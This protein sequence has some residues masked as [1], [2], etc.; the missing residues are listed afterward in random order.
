[1][2]I[3]VSIVMPTHNRY[4]LNRLTLYSLEAQ[5]YDH[6]RFEVILVDDASTDATPSI[7]QQEA[8][9]FDV[10]YFRMPANIGRPQARNFGIQVARGEYVMFLDAEVLVEPDFIASHMNLHRAQ[11]RLIVGGL[12]AIQ[13][14]YTRIDPRFSPDQQQEALELLVR[15]PDLH[16]RWLM[17]KHLPDPPPL[18]D[19][20]G[21]MEGQYKRMSA[22]LASYTRHMKEQVIDRYGDRFYGFHLPWI[23]SGTGSLSLAHEA[24]QVHGL[25]EEY[26]GWGA[27]DI[28][29]GYRLFINGY[30]F[31]HLSHSPTYHQEHPREAS[32][33]EEGKHNFYLFQ[34]KHPNISMLAI[35]LG[36]MPR[37][38]SF[39][40]I[41]LVLNDAYAVGAHEH[42]HR[43]LHLTGTFRAMLAAVGRL[44]RYGLPVT[45]LIAQ[46]GF[47]V[48]SP[49]SHLFYAE[50]Q[51]L[52]QTGKYPSL[53]YALDVLLS[54]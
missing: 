1:M 19:R 24:F 41:N 33:T 13:K 10:R 11:S 31:A 47:A 21:I 43:F 7:T 49:E 44:N 34:Q 37:G 17:T 29:M 5:T 18:F 50:K 3:D 12:Y 26:P 23:S 14:A 4:P 48:P 51:A 54:L 27:D 6:A 9:S 40:E 2:P 42:P 52:A 28:E 22:G 45:N 30:Q 36:Y 25:F 20:T 39:G 46:C 8:F 15:H 38:L 35:L 32:T 53:N 16:Q